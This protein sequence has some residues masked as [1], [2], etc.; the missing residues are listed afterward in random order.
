MSLCD[1]LA[2]CL[3]AGLS[4]CL[5]I[6]LS[7]CLS[8]CLYFCLSVCLSI[9]L[10]I[11]LIKDMQILYITLDTHNDLHVQCTLHGDT[12]VLYV[13]PRRRKSFRFLLSP[14]VRFVVF[15]LSCH[16]LFIM[17][18]RVYLSEWSGVGLCVCVGWG[19]LLYPLLT[20]FNCL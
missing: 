18:E 15:T 3:P 11:C 6:F 12:N 9:F 20:F 10:S 7:I 5:S 14:S 8:V 1:C 19:V 13:L 16:F 4:V 17:H 2:A